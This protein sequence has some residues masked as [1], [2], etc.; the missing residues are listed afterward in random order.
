MA[1]SLVRSRRRSDRHCSALRLV[2][3]GTARQLREESV[4]RQEA[5]AC[6]T[7]HSPEELQLLLDDGIGCARERRFRGPAWQRARQGA[8]EP[9]REHG[10]SRCARN[11][12]GRA[13]RRARRSRQAGG[14]VQLC[15]LTS[16]QRGRAPARPQPPRRR[17]PGPSRRRARCRPR[18]PATRR[19]CARP[20]C[21][22]TL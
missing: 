22:A 16:W 6:Q 21:T 15:Q 13:A 18:L 5:A 19:R 11:I 8:S 9:E 10:D 20:A 7:R 4:V 17:R 14:S 3:A 2:A 12:S 1:A